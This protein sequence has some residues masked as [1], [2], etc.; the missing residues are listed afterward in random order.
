VTRGRGRPA[1]GPVFDEAA[2]QQLLTL[3]ADGA[4]LGEA[5]AAVGI[6]RNLPGHHARTD[7]AFARQLEEALARGKTARAERV[8]HGE[9]RY[10]VLGC[11]C[12][13]I[14]TP[15]ASAARSGRR[16]TAAEETG[17][18]PVR[19]LTPATAP[20]SPTSF[21]LPGRSSPP[22]SRAA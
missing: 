8:P 17:P 6:H 14:C 5:A 21:L 19:A 4:R 7:K 12:K 22:G 1:R 10:N 9:Y 3:L 2:K 11:R 20:E 18:T 13:E 15:A 16:H